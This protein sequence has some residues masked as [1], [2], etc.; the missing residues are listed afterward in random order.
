MDT[1]VFVVSPP[2]YSV[3]SNVGL[4]SPVLSGLGVPSLLSDGFDD[5]KLTG[6]FVISSPPLTTGYSVGLIV[7]E[8]S[9]G[10]HP[11]EGLF[12]LPSLVVETLDGSPGTEVGTVIGAVTG[13]SIPPSSTS[14]SGEE[15]GITS[16]GL[17][18]TGAYVFV[19]SI[20]GCWTIGAF[21]TE[22]VSAIGLL[23][24]DTTGD[25]LT[26][27]PSLIVGRSDGIFST[28]GD[29]RGA[30]VVNSSTGLFVFPA[31]GN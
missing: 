3:G 4:L 2:L 21:V 30:L 28:L 9:V 20:D 10:F 22:S 14:R 13:A 5:G 23:V 11:E 31:T 16:T 27:P 19:V 7:V 15:L 17:L 26:E 8:S 25:K 1:G 29:A 18:V 12:V 6:A 24:G